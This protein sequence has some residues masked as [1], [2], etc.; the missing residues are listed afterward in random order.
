MNE[1]K[2]T[3]NVKDQSGFLPDFA[4]KTEIFYEKSDSAQSIKEKV[5]T[6]M[7]SKFGYELEF[8]GMNYSVNIELVK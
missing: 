2:V 7:Q 3:V 8:G 1:Y 5:D 6:E 4:G